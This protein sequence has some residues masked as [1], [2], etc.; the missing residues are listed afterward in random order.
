V[1]TVIIRCC[2]LRLLAADGE[3]KHPITCEGSSTR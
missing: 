3:Q 1:R 2:W